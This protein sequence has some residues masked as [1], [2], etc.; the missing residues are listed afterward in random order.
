MRPNTRAEFEF[1]RGFNALAKAKANRVRALGDGLLA[2]LAR[3]RLEDTLMHG[4]VLHAYG[5][6]LYQLK[7]DTPLQ[8]QLFE[9]A[10]EIY[11]REPERDRNWYADYFD[12]SSKLAHL[13]N[14][15][16][17][18]DAFHAQATKLLLIPAIGGVVNALH[19]SQ[20]WR[21]CAETYDSLCS[22]QLAVSAAEMALQIHAVSI[23]KGDQRLLTLQDELDELYEKLEAP[24]S[25]WREGVYTD[26]RLCARCNAMVSLE[27]TFLL[28]PVCENA[29]F[30]S[31]KCADTHIQNCASDAKQPVRRVNVRS[32]SK[33][34]A[35]L[36]EK[37]PLRCTGCRRAR[38]CDTD[39]QRANWKFHQPL[40]SEK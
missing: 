20:F 19:I 34:M 37:A 16:H 4:A 29:V 21:A 6:R 23:K 40:C 25:M 36:R 9:A 33:C 26:L 38:Y 31:E 10:S 2:K 18:F 12:M 1:E 7:L 14:N 32:R 28:C 24:R 30:C 17:R 11:E 35:C 3:E 13:Y 39:C 27:G 8:M 15:E 22:F 5:A